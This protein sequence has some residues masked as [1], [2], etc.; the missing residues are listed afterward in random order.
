MKSWQTIVA[1]SVGSV[2]VLLAAL[3]LGFALSANGDTGRLNETTVRLS[4][5]V[6][7]LEANAPPLLEGLSAAQAAIDTF[8][9]IVRRDDLASLSKNL[10]DLA[11]GQSLT[12]EDVVKMRSAIAELG[13]KVAELEA[14][15]SASVGG[16]V[17]VADDSDP[18]LSIMNSGSGPTL[19]GNFSPGASLLH[20]ERQDDGS[21]FDIVLDRDVTQSKGRAPKFIASALEM[22]WQLGENVFMT[23]SNESLNVRARLSV[24]GNFEPQNGVLAEFR[25]SESRP[26]GVILPRVTTAAR[27]AIHG[28]HTGLIVYNLD[29]NKLNLFDGSKWTEIQSE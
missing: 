16:R 8:S 10:A 15:P 3:S 26:Q 27:D 4:Q 29:T 14:N 2:L 23:L 12:T 6:A 7:V 9:A 17:I 21:T 1:I 5:K 24:G 22:E 28:S 20:L 19:P 11:A 18:A 13:T 25:T